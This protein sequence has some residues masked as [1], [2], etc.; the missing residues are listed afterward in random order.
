MADADIVLFL[1][2]ATNKTISK[3]DKI[4]INKLKEKNKKVILVINKIDK[5]QKH[6]LLELISKYKEEYNFEEVMPISA[7][8][9]NGTEELLNRIEKLL[10]LGPAYY[11]KDE[12][13]DQT[14]RDIASEVIREKALKLLDDEV[15]HGIYVEIE[16]MKQRKTRQ[17]EPIYD[18]NAVIYCLRDSHKGI[19]IGKKGT[20]LKKIAM[21]A[22]EDLE[23]NFMQKVNLQVWVKVKENWQ[24][25][26]NFLKKFKLD[27]E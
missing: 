20:M 3:G 11:D 27:K 24:E 25:D 9:K 12:Y 5:I 13:T 7:L 22:R 18:I 21:Y 17:K 8:N 6:N 10:P 19:I 4:L 1:I 16:K 26:N 2:D 23:K 14:M 15:P